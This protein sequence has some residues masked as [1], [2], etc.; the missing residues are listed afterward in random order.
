MSEAESLKFLD[1]L[2]NESIRE[3]LFHKHELR[4]KNNEFLFSNSE[5]LALE[6]QLDFLKL[7]RSKK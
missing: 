7:E 2:K 6:K 5:F 1:E 4:R 3:Q